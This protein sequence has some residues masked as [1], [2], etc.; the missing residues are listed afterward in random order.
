MVIFIQIL[1]SA[2]PP[3]PPLYSVELIVEPSS[4]GID[5]Y[6]EAERSEHR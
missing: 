5:K 2:V 6:P 1:A 4:I 3:S